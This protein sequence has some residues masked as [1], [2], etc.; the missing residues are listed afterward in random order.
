MKSR[1]K[2]KMWYNKTSMIS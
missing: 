2:Q 1:S